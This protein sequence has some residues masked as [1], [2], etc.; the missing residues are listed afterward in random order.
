MGK[1]SESLS[2]TDILIVSSRTT[3]T[4]TV[5]P[6]PLFS[7]SPSIT[8]RWEAHISLC[9]ADS[10]VCVRGYSSGYRSGSEPA[11]ET[12][13]QLHGLPDSKR[14]IEMRVVQNGVAT[15]WVGMGMRVGER[16]RGS[17][18]ERSIGE[19]SEPAP[20]WLIVVARA[21]SLHRDR[22]HPRASAM[23]DKPR[24]VLRSTL[25]VEGIDG[26][27]HRRSCPSPPSSDPAQVQS[28]LQ[29]ANTDLDLGRPSVFN[30]SASVRTSPACT[31]WVEMI[32]LGIGVDRRVVG[33]KAK[34]E[35]VCRQRCRCG[36]ERPTTVGM[37]VYFSGYHLSSVGQ[38]RKT[39]RASKNASGKKWS[40]TVSHERNAGCTSNE[41]HSEP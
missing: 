35:S 16:Q 37:E 17:A 7:Q 36:T 31:P 38:G 26:R 23:N 19:W 1:W 41:E 4:S 5:L 22:H 9:S 33:A 34:E 39:K 3:A 8:R 18:T 6:T 11:A 27:W 2:H 10:S 30:A 40:C 12:T 29:C 20:W 32:G 25:Q 21:S 24:R 15:V 28:G 13:A 14:D